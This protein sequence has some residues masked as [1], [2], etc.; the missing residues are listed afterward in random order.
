MRN[1]KQNIP[2]KPLPTLLRGRLERF[3]AGGSPDVV[4]IGGLDRDDVRRILGALEHERQRGDFGDSLRQALPRIPKKTVAAMYEAGRERRAGL[5]LPDPEVLGQAIG[6][7][8]AVVLVK[9]MGV[10][11][12]VQR[13]T[14][15]RR[16]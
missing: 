8:L 12:Q 10:K 16:G 4:Y 9:H 6:K 11:P 1:T 5:P 14:G 3:A 2:A 7:A 13:R 15:G